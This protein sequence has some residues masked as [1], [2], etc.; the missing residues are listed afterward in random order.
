M[1]QRIFL[2]TYMILFVIFT[3]QTAAAEEEDYDLDPRLYIYYAQLTEDERD[4]YVQALEEFSAGISSFAPCRG[5]SLDS[6]NR[7]MHAIWIS[8]SCSGWMK[9][10][11]IAI[12]R[13][14]PGQKK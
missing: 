13:D 14:F 1:K 8:H 3:I 4:V 10:F 9:A 12:G 7:I 5:I 11:S 6:A 2:I